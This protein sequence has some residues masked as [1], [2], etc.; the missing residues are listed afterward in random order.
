MRCE[1]SRTDT[2]LLRSSRRWRS[3]AVAT[4]DLD[5]D[6]KM[7]KQC[8]DVMMKRDE[9]RSRIRSLPKT[10]HHVNQIVNQRRG[11]GFSMVAPHRCNNRNDNVVG[12][13]D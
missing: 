13:A 10:L 9:W 4:A 12:I 1:D 7:A 5:M 3:F 8:D 6:G 11:S 2:A